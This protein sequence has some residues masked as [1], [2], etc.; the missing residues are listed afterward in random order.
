M[1]QVF[2]IRHGQ[3]GSRTDYDRLSDTG[4]QQAALLG[5]WLARRRTRFEAAFVGGLQRQAETAEIVLA[6]MRKGGVEPPPLVQDPRWSEFDIDRV[7]AAIAPLLAEKDSQFRLWHDQLIANIR[8]GNGQVHREWTP[9]DTR[10]VRSWIEGEF[11]TGCESWEQFT[12]R[13]GQ[14]LDD[15]SPPGRIAVF[16]S[17]TPAGICVS[18]CFDSAS[19]ARIMGL[20][21]AAINTNITTVVRRDGS[22]LLGGF[23]HVPHLE[24]PS[25]WTFR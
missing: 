16:T 11:E 25:L 22:W 12:S 17:A 6:E 10:V 20:A 1:T 3:A 2:L 23:N 21:G 7:F 24:D 4:K 13:V 18:R 14:A 15:L 19:P 8:S 5:Q 9:A